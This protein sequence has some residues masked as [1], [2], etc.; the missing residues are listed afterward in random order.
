MSLFFT[1]PKILTDLN[2]ELSHFP[3]KIVGTIPKWLQGTY[4][5]NGPVNINIDDGKNRHWL[6]GLAML[7]AFQFKNGGVF[8]TNKFLRT[9][10]Y[11]RVFEQGS[12]N[13][14]GLATSFSESLFQELL[15]KLHLNHPWRMGNTNANVIFSQGKCLA[16]GEKS[17]PICF[18]LN[19]LEIEKASQFENFTDEQEYWECS[20][21]HY[22]VNSK[23]Y[24]NYRVEFGKPSYYVFYYLNVNGQSEVLA[25]IPVSNPSYM[26]SFAITENYIILTEFPLK[27]N[28]MENANFSFMDHYKWDPVLGTDFLVIDRKNGQ[29]IG[30]YNMVP[31]FAFHHVNA[32]ENDE[33]IHLDI[34]CYDNASI[35]L[36]LADHCRATSELENYSP[37]RLVRFS[38]SIKEGKMTS[39]VLFKKFNDF[40]SINQH[41]DG[42]VYQYAYLCDWRDTMLINEIRPLY[43]ISL[44]SK[45]VKVWSEEGCYPGEPLFINSPDAHHE[46][47]GIILSIVIEAEKYQ[48]FLL[49]LDAQTFTEIG[50]VL[51][52]HIIPSGLHGKFFA[53]L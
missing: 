26:Q 53:D 2:E 31:F 12:L 22:D 48:S 28:E 41:F 1:K 21:P 43:K 20:H 40:P 4:V 37:S 7:H 30:R 6:D 34:V 27:R 18:D 46:D 45:E 11:K 36:K 13:Y 24:I 47:E 15:E 25:K 23:K 51:V 42:K 14:P 9:D 52:P 49:I 33:Q 19:T 17:H 50:R 32:F 39:H 35:I 38:L 44:Q 10:C 8:Y 29:I 16:L 3:L 5:R